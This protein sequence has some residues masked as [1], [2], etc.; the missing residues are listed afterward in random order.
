[1][2][3]RKSLL[4]EAKQHRTCPPPT[5][6]QHMEHKMTY[7][8]HL[9]ICPFCT[10]GKSLEMAGW[11]QIA[12]MI[13]ANC[14]SESAGR[15]HMQIR[16]GQLR[17]IRQDRAA[18]Q[19][20]QYYS[21]P[22]VL[23]VEVTRAESD[24]VLVAQTYWDTGLAAPGDLILGP[25]QTGLQ[26]IDLFAETWNTYTI[27]ASHLEA[28]FG[29]NVG[30]KVVEAVCKMDKNPDYHPAW[31]KMPRPMSDDHDP[32]IYFRKLEIEVGAVF[33]LPAVQEL[34]DELAGAPVRQ[35]SV[36]DLMASIQGFIPDAY[37]QDTP[38]TMEETIAMARFRRLS[39]EESDVSEITA[40]LAVF[41]DGALQHFAVLSA[42]VLQ[43]QI[44]EGK[45]AISGRIQKPPAPFTNARLIGF[46]E[47]AGSRPLASCREA[48]D[49]ET[50]SFYIEFECGK[51]LEGQI[52]IAVL[53]S[54]SSHGDDTG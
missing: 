22:L 51:Y 1:M 47:V 11:T 41:Q 18:W 37:W 21:P 48:L 14:K 13:L 8:H 36:Q 26:G 12:E 38:G 28:P 29:K 43:K 6:A 44:S 19:N 3:T 30:K 33:S 16:P 24:V 7:Q 34:M 20:G 50:G 17:F 32:R 39:A 46:L 35:Y 42:D 4:A 27:R 49:D 5:V 9:S 2:E 45:L 31:A 25:S 15:K 53:I 40:K 52:E 54:L 10:S 23:V